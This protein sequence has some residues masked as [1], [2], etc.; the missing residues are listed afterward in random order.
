MVSKS[1]SSQG[2]WRKGRKGIRK[3]I[4][5]YKQIPAPWIPEHLDTWGPSQIVS[6]FLSFFFFFLFRAAP[7]AY[8]SP[9]FRGQI[10]AA[11][12]AYATAI[13]TPDLSHICNLHHTLWQCQILNS[14]SKARDQTH[15]LMAD[16]RVLN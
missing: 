9:Q 6:F 11:A 4:D 5:R 10:G 15:I 16:G 12:G 14:L 2:G 7:M 1:L 8:G 13:A 3:W